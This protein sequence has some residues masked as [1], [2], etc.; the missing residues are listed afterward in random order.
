MKLVSAVEPLVDAEAVSRLLG[1]R[2]QRVYSLAH[3]DG[4]PHYLVG[5]YMRFRVSE[6]EEWIQDQRHNGAQ[7]EA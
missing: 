5:R 3:D 2:K 6:V 7:A 1:V 4:L